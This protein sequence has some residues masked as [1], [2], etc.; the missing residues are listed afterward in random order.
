MKFARLVWAN[1]RRNKR[2]TILTT[3]SVAVALF[4]FATLRSVLTTLAGAAE[5]GSETRL[6]TTNTISIVFP[7]PQ[8]YYERLRAMEGVEAVSWANW[9]GGVYRDP[10]DFFASFAV[11]S[12]TYWP[13][14]PEIEVPPEQLRAYMGERTAAIVGPELMKRYGWK[15]GDR[16]SLRGTIYPG[17]WP[18]TIRGV[19]RA[20]TKYIDEASFMFHWDYLYEKSDRQADVGWYILQLSDP[21][22]APAVAKRIDDTFRNSSASTETATE[23]AFQASFIT[24]WGN[25]GFFLNAIGLAVFFAILLVAANTMMM[26]ARERTTEHAVLKALG[27]GDRLLFGIVMAEAA[28]VTLLGGLIGVLAARLLFSAATPFDSWMPGFSVTWPTIGLGLAI[29]LVIGLMAG[30]IPALQAARLPVV[31]ALRRVA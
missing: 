25:V 13:I 2:R 15:V 5:V 24:M 12:D 22:L 21:A 23:R 29:A 19:Y 3:L 28:I 11:D 16:V 18:F 1:L 6:I 17:D 4:L 30:L 9:F 14:Y 20:T 8:S 26:A 7:L 31:Q 10:Q 27:Y